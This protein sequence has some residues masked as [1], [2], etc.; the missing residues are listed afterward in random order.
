MVISSGFKVCHTSAKPDPPCPSS[1]SGYVLKEVVRTIG[2]KPVSSQRYDMWTRVAPW[3]FQVIATGVLVVYIS[4]G[5]RYSPD[6]VAVDI[7]H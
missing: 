2:V 6:G 4:H 1:R 3:V 5:N 7:W